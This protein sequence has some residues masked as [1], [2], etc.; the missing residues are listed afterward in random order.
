MAGKSTSERSSVLG[1]L[2][3]T[4]TGKTRGRIEFENAVNMMRIVSMFR[5]RSVRGV[6]D[7]QLT[8]V[9]HVG[10]FCVILLLAIF[11]VLLSLLSVILLFHRALF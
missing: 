3:M 8:F 11:A 10:C 6:A 9:L 1:S 5:L 7:S 2:G 4:K